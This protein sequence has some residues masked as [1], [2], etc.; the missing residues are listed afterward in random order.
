LI[1]YIV[2]IFTRFIYLFLLLCGLKSFKRSFK[3][4]DYVLFSILGE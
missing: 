1:K 3:S 4:Y 2:F